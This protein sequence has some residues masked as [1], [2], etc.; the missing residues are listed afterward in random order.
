MEDYQGNSKREREGKSEKK[1]RPPKENIEKVVT[2]EVIQ[3]PKGIGRKFKDIFLGGDAK[4]AAVFVGRDVL[5][6]ALKNLVVDMVTKGAERLV[7]GTDSRYSRRP[8]V[9]YRGIS[10]GVPYNRPLDLRDPRERTYPP[11]ALPRG[12]QNRHDINDVVLATKEEADLVTERLADIMDK[13]DVVSLM[14]LYDL[15]GLQTSPIDNKWGWTY[16][17]N[18]DVRQIRQGYLLE[19]PPLEEI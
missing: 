6:P 14:D 19:L 3:K 5:I 11:Q 10:Q 17:G 1:N 15:L 4:T 12:R 7:Y 16:L 8:T 2:G 9:N 13:Y 18:I